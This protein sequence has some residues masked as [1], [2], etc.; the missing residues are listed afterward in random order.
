M[1]QDNLNKIKLKQIKALKIIYILLNTYFNLI[2]L[3]ISI[4]KLIFVLISVTKK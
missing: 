2:F 4:I 1:L 3:L